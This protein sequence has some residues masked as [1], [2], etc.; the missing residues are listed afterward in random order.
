MRKIILFLSL[1]FLACREKTADKPYEATWLKIKKTDN[2]YIVYNYPSLWGDGT[3]KSPE[4]VRAKGDSLTWIIYSDDPAGLFYKFNNV[5]K[6][7][8]SSYKFDF[9]D[10]TNFRFDYVDKANH[11]A[12]WRVYYSYGGESYG[13][14][15]F[16][17]SLYNT[18]PIVDYEW[19]AGPILGEC[20]PLCLPEDRSYE[21]AWLKLTK[22][23][24]GYVVYN[25]PNL[26]DGGKTKSPYIIKAQERELTFITSIKDAYTMPFERVDKTDSGFYFLQIGN[27]HE[28]Q[29]VDKEKH[30]AKWI[31]HFKWTDESSRCGDEGK[32]LDLGM[33]IDSLYNTFPIVDY[34]WKEGAENTICDPS[35]VRS[36]KNKPKAT[37]PQ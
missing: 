18:F 2:G 35:T 22:I 34:E 10:Y 19:K 20:D 29:W 5:V 14:D 11:I 9:K 17:D 1:A 28:F 36:G 15:L 6:L 24:S 16:I 31:D 21:A 13:D 23:D 25:C 32:L 4:I 26:Q 37:F 7:N 30:I 33:Y 12:R 27:C 8:D 3:T